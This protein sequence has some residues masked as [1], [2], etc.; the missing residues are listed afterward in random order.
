MQRPE[1][2]CI[3]S[4]ALNLRCGLIRARLASSSG[5]KHL[6]HSFLPYLSTH[7]NLHVGQAFRTSRFGNHLYRRSSAGAVVDLLLSRFAR[8]TGFRGAYGRVTGL[9]L[10]RCEGHKSSG[11]GAK[12]EFA[13]LNSRRMG[14]SCK[15][16]W[17]FAAVW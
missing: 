11:C 16:N 17:I 5:T 7:S 15:S 6:G 10:G 4:A 3:A 14:T 2:D 12:L 8:A 9:G 13:T 1:A